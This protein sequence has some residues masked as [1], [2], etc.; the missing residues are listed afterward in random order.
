V[1]FDETTQILT[2]LQSEYPQSFAKMDERMMALK[3]RLWFSEFQ[4]DDYKAV[5]AVVRAIMSAG[6][7]EFAPNIS[8]IRE[9]LR[10]YSTD[11]EMSEQE[12]WAMVSKAICNG[13]Y[14]Y[15][16]EY[17]K[18]PPPIQKAVGQPEQLK[19]WAVMDENDVQSV[20]ASNFQR[21][22]RAI[23]SRER[24]LSKI[25]PDVRAMLEGV[26]ENMM[27]GEGRAMTD[28]N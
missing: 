8:K 15:K 1:T 27:L 20:V 12:A 4:Y 26:G 5:Y 10:S 9:K 16:E 3:Q 7:R 11:G 13:I 6:D 19:R 24:E 21:S 28:G 2:L 22:F 14:G 23:M 17:E 25:P 18:L